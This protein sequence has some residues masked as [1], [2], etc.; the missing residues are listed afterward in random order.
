MLTVVAVVAWPLSLLSPA[1]NSTVTVALIFMIFTVGLSV[2]VGNSGVF[3]FGHMGFAMMGGYVGSLMAMPVEL[4]RT[5]LPQAPEFILTT[6]LP[7]PLAIVVAGLAA[8]ALAAVLAWPL[9]RLNG[10]AAGLATV[11]VLMAMY[12]IATNWR[13]VTKGAAGLSS[14]I[15]TTTTPSTLAWL[16]VALVL[17]WAFQCSRPGRLLRA[18]RSDEIAAAASGVNIP[19]VRSLAFVLSAFITG[20]G[21]ALFAM[22]AGSVSPATFYLDGTFAVITMLVVGGFRSLTGAVLGSAVVAVLTEVTG[23]VERGSFFG[24]FEVPA[25]PGFSSMALGLLLVVILLRRPRGLVG[26]WELRWPVRRRPASDDPATPPSVPATAPT[27]L[28]SPER[29][30][31]C[32]TR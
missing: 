19:L 14:N 27:D 21:G 5:L 6:V 22:H 10:L 12:V 20:I 17:A 32:P 8:T 23:I 7:G 15:R 30:T 18:S 26:T 16:G 13:D 4:K 9:S 1:L 11:S 25:L 3:S 31:T 29:D 28:P 2:F 24:L